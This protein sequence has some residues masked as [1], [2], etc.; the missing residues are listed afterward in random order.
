MLVK[1]A[2]AETAGAFALIETA[3]P[4]HAGP[5]LHLHRTVDEAFYVLEGEYEFYCGSERVEAG[6]GAFVLLPRGVPHRY[7]TGA[8]GGR[9]LMLF[10]PGGTEEYFRE[11]AALMSSTGTSEHALAELADRHGIVLLDDY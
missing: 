11:L 6:P 9:V 3:N 5:P 8:D 2:A 7:R 4:P 10:S 1:A